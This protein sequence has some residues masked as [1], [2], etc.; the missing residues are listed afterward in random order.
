V[1]PACGDAEAERVALQMVFPTIVED[2]LDG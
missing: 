1:V 2:Q